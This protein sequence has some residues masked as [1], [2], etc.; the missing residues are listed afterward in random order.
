M[1]KFEKINIV[2]KSNNL[3]GNTEARRLAAGDYFNLLECDIDSTINK[4]NTSQDFSILNSEPCN[5]FLESDLRPE[6]VIDIINQCRYLLATK[7]TFMHDV[8]DEKNKMTYNP[9]NNYYVESGYYGNSYS[10]QRMIEAYELAEK[11]LNDKRTYQLLKLLLKYY[12][13]KSQIRDRQRLFKLLQDPDQSA[14]R[15]ELIKLLQTEDE[16]VG[17]VRTEDSQYG[18]SIDVG[19]RKDMAISDMIGLPFAK[20][21]DEP[22]Y[23]YGPYDSYYHEPHKITKTFHEGDTKLHRNMITREKLRRAQN[24]STLY[25]SERGF[26]MSGGIALIVSQKEL[27]EWGIEPS[28]VKWQPLRITINPQAILTIKDSRGE[29]IPLFDRLAVKV[30]T[31]TR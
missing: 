9:N 4:F 26:I 28:R 24:D 12:G 14:K 6:S 21:I 2:R 30:K 22:G 16:E 10:Y 8:E 18:V 11:I 13:T 27:V 15:E 19:T 23:D 3:L 20:D 17:I 7:S 25:S 5:L 1:R 29:R 31:L